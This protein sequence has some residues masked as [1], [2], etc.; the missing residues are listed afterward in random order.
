MGDVCAGCDWG[1]GEILSFVLRL[2][3]YRSSDQPGSRTQNHLLHPVSALI[4]ATISHQPLPPSPTT[5]LSPRAI[6]LFLNLDLFILASPPAAYAEYAL[7]IR[8]E[9]EHVPEHEY[10]VGRTKVLGVFLEREQL[11][12]GSGWEEEER[13]ARENMRREIDGLG[14]GSDAH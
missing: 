1:T 5:P 3:C 8:A 6:H 7:A 2:T 14:E 11:Y 13:V 12:F 9:Y 10:K 4:L